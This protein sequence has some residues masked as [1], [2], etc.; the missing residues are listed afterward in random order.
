M[1]Y[2]GQLLCMIRKKTVVITSEKR[3]NRVMNRLIVGWAVLVIL[4]LLG[5]HMFYL[6]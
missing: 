6:I 3:L 5:I 4:A 1:S 2:N